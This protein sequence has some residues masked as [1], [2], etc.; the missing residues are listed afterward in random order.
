MKTY[1]II[2]LIHNVDMDV[3]DTTIAFKKKLRIARRKLSFSLLMH[4]C[5]LVGI[6]I[7]ST[8]T[9]ASHFINATTILNKIWKCLYWIQKMSSAHI[10]Q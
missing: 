7:T 10:T 4:Q 3:S 1:F 8:K 5:I 9:I 2:V 6:G